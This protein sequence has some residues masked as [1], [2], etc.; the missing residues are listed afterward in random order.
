MTSSNVLTAGS[1]PNRWRVWLEASR[2][3]SF[4]ASV[5]PV[6]IGSALAALAGPFHWG[7]FLLALCGSLFL[8]IGTNMINDYYDYVNGVDTPETLGPSQVIQRG[9][10]SAAE[11][12]WG[13][14]ATF[15]IGSVFGLIL[16][17]LCGWPIL[18][19][20][21]VSVLAGYFY[22]ANPL[23]LAYIALGEVTVFI[24]MGP[25]IVMGAFF[26]QREMFT[27]TSFLV[28]LPVGCLV[29]AI[30]HAN[31]I[32]DLRHDQERG[33]HTLATVIGRSSAN[34]ELAGFVYGAFVITVVLVLFGYAPWP[35]LLTF[36]TLRHAIPAVR[37]PLESETTEKLNDAL[38]HTVKLHLEY[39][40]LLAVGLLLSRFLLYRGFSLTVIFAQVELT[41]Q[42][43]RI[44]YFY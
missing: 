7:R 26:V 3:F 10:L 34:W 2:P 20:G 38:M 12:Y 43:S 25:V 1:R 8:Q 6:V 22:T 31:N 5:T 4:T 28:S 44:T 36:V 14:I 41:G 16:V 13:G 19:P 30:L 40:I 24:F 32:R 9:L 23:S 11:M 15:A 18:A 17:A 39:G 27:L 35:V 42:T 29:A 33:K 21:L 37:I